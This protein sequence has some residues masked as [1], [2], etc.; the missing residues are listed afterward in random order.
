MLII[1]SKVESIEDIVVVNSNQPRVPV[2]ETRELSHQFLEWD[3]I[4]D[5]IR[6][7][8]N[9]TFSEDALKKFN[10][11]EQSQAS[12]G[13]ELRK[14]SRL[15]E[16]TEIVQDFGKISRFRI[17]VWW[18]KHC[19]FQNAILLA[20]PDFFEKDNSCDA[21]NFSNGNNHRT[22]TET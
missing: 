14:G 11:D 9:T 17:S 7:K 19:F 21:S 2:V 3:L 12:I 8:Q 6:T 5:P 15:F 16:M 18:L 22:V 1:H 10:L 4:Q 20:F 13:N